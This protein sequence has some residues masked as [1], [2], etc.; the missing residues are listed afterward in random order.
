MTVRQ[1]DREFRVGWKILLIALLGVVTSPHYLGL[2]SFGPL[3]QDLKSALD[4]PIGELQRAITF[5]FVGIAVGSQLAG[6]LLGRFEPR[7][8]IL[9]SLIL[10]SAIYALLGIVDLTR[11]TLYLFY[12]I[13]P[14]AGSGAL[15][16]T[17]TQIACQNFE[18]NR[19]LALAII[20]TGG[21]IISTAAPLIL[22]TVVGTEH[23]QNAFFI[24]A[25]MPL[26]TFLVCFI[27]LPTT[28]KV[29]SDPGTL[30][31]AEETPE[32]GLTFAEIWR[33]WRFWIIITASVL[34]ILVVL[35]LITNIVPLLVEKGLSQAKANRIYSTFGLSLIVGR[36]LGGYLIDRISGPLVAFGVMILP[37]FSCLLFLLAPAHPP[38]MVLATV[39]VGFS[40][41]AEYD[42]LAYLISRYFGLKAY[43]KTYG[44]LIAITTLG[45]GMAPLIYGPIIDAAGDYNLFLMLGSGAV[46]IGAPL[47]LTLGSYPKFRQTLESAA[48]DH[49][50][51]PTG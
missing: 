3:V 48:Q 44:A 4:I 20:L 21:G 29:Q 14:I 43:G 49:L 41:G 27:A 45:S 42:I 23:W 32:S 35:S 26:F 36:L 31:Q 22:S 46:F 16:V 11:N 50:S 7:S 24:L 19:G 33:T 17:W 40:A 10:F 9:L 28:A 47:F 5:N 8:V 39:L 18:K 6:W 12:L 13:L 34:V 15:L 2:Y 25:L 51:E 30:S 38:I 1:I 37:A